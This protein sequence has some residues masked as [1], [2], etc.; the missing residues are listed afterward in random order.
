MTPTQRARPADRGAGR[1]GRRARRRGGSGSRGGT[2]WSSRSRPTTRPTC[3][4]S[5]GGARRRR[6]VDLPRRGTA[7]RRGG[8]GGGVGALA[9]P[10]ATRSRTPL[11]PARHR[12]GGRGRELLPDRPG[13]RLDR[14]RRRSLRPLPPADARRTEAIRL[15]AGYVFDDLGY[16]RFEWK[17]DSCNEPSAAAA[18]R[19]GFTLRGPVPQ[20]DGLQG[21]QPRHRLVR[22]DR[23]RVAVAP[24]RRTSAWLDPANF[25]DDGRQRTALSD[26]TA[27]AL[28][29]H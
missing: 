28:P 7:G 17:L 1:L 12:P 3:S 19:L 2:S 4:T 20:R 15:L 18:R 6:A 16:R 25:D 8:P 24:R 23:R 14:G 10:R 5:L 21:P 29:A 22:D 13:A 9:Q 26:L 27:A 11:V